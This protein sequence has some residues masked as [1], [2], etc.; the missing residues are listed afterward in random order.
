MNASSAGSPSAVLEHDLESLFDFDRDLSC[1]GS[2]H[3]RGLSGHDST[4]PGAYKVISP[5]CGPKIVQCEPRVLAMKAS[6]VLYCGTCR[7]DHLTTEY[8]FIPL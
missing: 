4:A 3:P 7:T 6:G 8:E 5:C 1:E 2:H